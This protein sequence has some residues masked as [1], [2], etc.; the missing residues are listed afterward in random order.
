MDQSEQIAALKREFD[1]KIAALTASKALTPHT[2]PV[3]ITIGLIAHNDWL[4]L[5][6]VLS[7]FGAQGEYV[8]VLLA[9]DST[10]TDPSKEVLEGFARWASGSL[11][12]RSCRYIGEIPHKDPPDQ[13]VAHALAKFATEAKT[14]FMWYN[15][16]D[17]LLPPLTLAKVKAQMVDGVGA[18]CVPYTYKSD[19]LEWGAMMMRRKVAEDVGFDGRGRCGC[20]NIAAALDAAGLKMVEAKDCVAYHLKYKVTMIGGA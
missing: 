12:L 9:T 13:T 17:V 10:S 11:Q 15:D 6:S 1:Q 20:V 8:D 4:S 5:P 18:V 16:A 19:H 3:D 7:A 2:S 14:E